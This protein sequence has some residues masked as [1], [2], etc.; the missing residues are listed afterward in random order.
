MPDLFNLAR[1]LTPEERNVQKTVRSFVDARV[2]PRRVGR[3]GVDREDQH[4]TRFLIA[5]RCAER[6]NRIAGADRAVRHTADDDQ[7]LTLQARLDLAQR[8]YREFHTRCF[9]PCPVLC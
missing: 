7:P 9:W 3:G 4:R 5:Q 1:H 8:L 6:R 2:L